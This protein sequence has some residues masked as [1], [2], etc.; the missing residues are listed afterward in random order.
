[1]TFL[2]ILAKQAVMKNMK[3]ECKC[4]GVSGSCS[5]RTCW[6]AMQEFRRV[7]DYLRLK[8]NAASEVIMNQDGTG[9]IAAGRNVKGPTRSNLVYFEKSPDYCKQ[10]PDTGKIL[11]FLLLVVHYFQTK[12]ELLGKQTVKNT[13]KVHLWPS[14][15][16][17]YLGLDHLI[18]HN[19][20][21]CRL[22][23]VNLSSTT[24]F[25]V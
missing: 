4:H 18:S 16:Y 23:F 10:D 22:Y 14:I 11:D 21:P 12:F 3:L 19:F 17:S 9:L 24:L 8:Y 1:M 25:S 15:Q 7:G 13:K 6:L 2:S 20:V 5:I